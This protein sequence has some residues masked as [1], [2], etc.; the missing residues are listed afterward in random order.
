MPKQPLRIVKDEFGNA[1]NVT[2]LKAQG[3]QGN[4]VITDSITVKDL[5]GTQPQDFMLFKRQIEENERRGM[6]VW[7]DRFISKQLKLTILRKLQASESG[8]KLL[9]SNSDFN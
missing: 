9:L 6:T 2:G 8:S 1:I 7:R 5:K 4:V 3:T